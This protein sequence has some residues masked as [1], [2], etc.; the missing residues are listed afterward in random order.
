MAGKPMSEKLQWRGFVI[1]S[2][3]DKEITSWKRKCSAPSML[4]LLLIVKKIFNDERK[5]FLRLL[6]ILC[7]FKI[8]Y[9]G[10]TRNCWVLRFKNK[11]N[12]LIALHWR[13]IVLIDQNRAVRGLCDWI[14]DISTFNR[15]SIYPYDFQ[16][17]YIKK[18]L[19]LWTYLTTVWNEKI[20]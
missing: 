9:L 17:H 16:P 13:A 14:L 1:N 20:I 4:L 3:E 2:P 11:N 18:D 8:L 12:I 15:H 7:Q 5:A 6:Y 10:Y 19:N